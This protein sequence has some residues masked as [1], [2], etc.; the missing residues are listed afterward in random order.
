MATLN[1]GRIIPTPEGEYSAVKTYKELSIVTKNGNSYIAKKESTGQDPETSSEFW[2]LIAAKGEQGAEGQQGVGIPT[3]GTAGQVLIKKSEADFDAQ[4]ETYQNGGGGTTI[5]TDATPTEGSTNPVQSGGVKVELNKI[6]SELDTKKSKKYDKYMVVCV[7]GQS[8]AVGYDESPIDEK[9]IYKNLDNNRIKQLGFYGEDNL[10]II[11][12]GY[13]AQNMQDMRT[14]SDG[15][16]IQDINGV[17][18][19]KGIHLPLSNLMLDY[20][21]DDYGVLVLP[22]AHGGTGFTGTATTGTYNPDT[23]KPNETGQGEGTGIQRWGSNTAYYQTLKNRIIH[24]LELNEENLFAGIVWCQGENDQ[25]NANDHYAAF[26]TM[27]QTLFDELNAHNGGALKSRVPKKEWDKDIWYNMETIYSWYTRGQ[28]RQ[29]WDNYKTWNPNTY[30]E[31]PSTSFDS[32]ETNGTRVTANNLA[33]HYGNN[34]YQRVVA[35]KVLQKMIDMNTFAKKVNIVELE[36]EVITPSETNTYPMATEATRVATNTDIAAERTL[37]FTIDENGKCTT[38]MDDFS[39]SF[40]KNADKN[41]NDTTRQPSISFGNVFKLDWEVKRGFYWVVI[42]GDINSNYLLLGVG[43]GNAGKLSKIHNNAIDANSIPGVSNVTQYTFQA[44][45]RIKIYRNSDN[46]LSIY[47]T[48]GLN[49]PF[50]K[51]FDCPNKDIYEEKML[52]FACGISSAE[53]DAPFNNERNVLF[54]DMKIQKQELFPNNKFI[55]LELSNLKRQLSI[56]EF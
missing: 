11:P 34:V 41:G 29:I 12:L 20:I 47:R 27:T 28:C 9:F 13:C 15:N 7:A 3:G 53:F 33:D 54:N 1:L 14:K 40:F 39:G 51:W 42:E 46:S 22:I 25:N 48:N 19:T 37:D 26:Q 45:D 36:S 55:D 24:A 43:K 18:G 30:V 17:R 6:N 38:D 35:P 49:T 31:I 5:V 52:G 16:P 4:W 2:Q 8:N 21:P 23:K 56:L 50:Q 44:G 32:N 10:K